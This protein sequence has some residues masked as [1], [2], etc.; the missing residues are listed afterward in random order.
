VALLDWDR[1][2]W[3]GF[4]AGV[5]G[6]RKDFAPKGREDEAYVRGLS[7]MQEVP[8][9][10]RAERSP[11]IVR[12]LNTWAC[13][14][15]GSLTPPL[16]AGWIRAHE[17]ELRRLEPF[18]IVDSELPA[19]A[20]AAGR[21][22][23]DLIAALRA[24]GVRNMS[25]AA[26]SKALHLLLPALFVMWDREIR[27]SAPAGYGDYLRR[28]HELALRLTAEA[29]VPAADVE[30]HLQQLLGA[31]T[32]KTLAKHLDEYNWYEAVGRGQLA[33]RSGP[34]RSSRETSRRRS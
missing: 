7:L 16:L 26:A 12:L 5:R 29:P 8:L 6:Y 23:D 34:P 20:D 9:A 14:L 13:R 27:G 19:H 4:V 31:S 15:S 17:A 3:D 33:A 10:R 21:L 30:A 11:D 22:H 32:R 24:G 28:M 18:T 2:T 25:D 1:L